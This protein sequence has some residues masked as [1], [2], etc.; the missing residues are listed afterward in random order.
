MRKMVKNYNKYQN[1]K[2]KYLDL[3]N[4]SEAT[5][6]TID[7][8]DMQIINRVF[9]AKDGVDF[10]KLKFTEESMYSMS[11]KEAVQILINIIRDN[12]ISLNEDEIKNIIITDG[13][14][15]IGSDSINLA[16]YFNKI[17]SVELSNITCKF[18]QNNVSLYG[19]QD[20]I[21]VTCGNTLDFLENNNQDVIYIDP[22]WGGVDYKKYDKMKLYLGSME[23]SDIINTFWDK[24]KLFVIKVPRNYDI[25]SF[26]NRINQ[27]NNK[28]KNGNHISIHTYKRRDKVIFYFIAVKI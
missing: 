2:K 9:P 12:F 6:K 18:L 4:K 3:K 13:T 17:N 20:K 21:N 7:N 10:S 5:E 27:P 8:K 16:T 26:I 14:A 1:Y 28:Y 22:P 11:G 19:F 24:T 25:I 15:N 23:V